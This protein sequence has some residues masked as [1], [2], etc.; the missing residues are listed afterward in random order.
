MPPM[1]DLTSPQLLAL[2]RWRG[3]D[4]GMQAL[5]GNV[6]HRYTGVFRVDGPRLVNVHLQDKLGEARPEALAVVELADSFCQFV[7][8][9]GEFMTGNSLHEEQLGS[10]PFRGVVLA[11]HGVPVGDNA[12]GL[13]GTLCHF[14]YEEREL[15]PAQYELLKAAGHM[16]YPF[17]R[18]LHGGRV[19]EA[20]PGAQ[21]PSASPLPLPS[22][23]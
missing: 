12:G 23:F 14:D 8:R 3:L 11:Y 7:L 20:A 10:H 22:V 21:A 13:W 17:V 2:L 6:A 18:H 1:H 16:L 9:D 19:P 15:A 4:A 5:N